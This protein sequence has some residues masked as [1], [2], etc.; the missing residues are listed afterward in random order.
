MASILKRLLILSI[1]VLGPHCLHAKDYGVY[2]HVFSIEEEDLLE[3]LQK[4]TNALTDKEIEAFQKN[5]QSKIAR[6]LTEPSPVKGIEEARS[7][8]VFYF[9]PTVCAKEAIKDQEGNIVVKKGTCVNPLQSIASFDDLLFF[10][11]THEDHIEWAKKQPKN[12]KWILVKG[13]PIELEKQENRP[14][15]FDQF[16]FITTKLN[17]KNVP[18]KVSKD[19]N[20]LKIEEIPMEGGNQ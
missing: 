10:D 6:G 17:I 7:Y 20:R 13:K 18:A 19:G 2:G 16:G 15:Y 12:A 11:A 1:A 4:K 9:D 14:I 5:V 8:R 3:V